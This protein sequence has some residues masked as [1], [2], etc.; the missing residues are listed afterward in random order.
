FSKPF[1]QSGIA[2]NDSITEGIGEQTGRH[3]KAYGTF[4]VEANESV[5]VQVALSFISYKGARRN[6]EAEAVDKD[7]DIAKAETVRKWQEKLSTIEVTGGTQ[8]DKRI[9]YTGLY[10]AMIA[11]NLI[12]DVDG[13]YMVEGE[14]YTDTANQYSTLSTWDTVRALHPLLTII[15]PTITAEI[16]N[17]LISRHFDS[18]V[19]LPV[20]ELTGHDNACM[21]GYTPVSVIVDAVRKGVPGIDREKAYQAIKAA[22]LYDPKGSRYA[23][24]Q[25]LPWIK[26]YN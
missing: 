20:W 11:P 17:S 12:S 23:G 21:T 25:I 10:H 2:V 4:D 1:K 13:N 14:V 22:S 15:D 8:E 5:E 7:F 3:V 6:F 16:T 9:F 19:E 26:K 18:R 24:G